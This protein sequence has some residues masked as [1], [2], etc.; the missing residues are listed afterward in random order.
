[1]ASWLPQLDE[2]WA[3]PEGQE[4]ILFSARSV[5]SEPSLIGLSAH[6]I[7]VTRTSR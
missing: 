5:E 3:T 1:L 7:A 2:H 4:A 6:L